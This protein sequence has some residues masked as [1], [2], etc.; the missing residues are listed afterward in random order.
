MAEENHSK[1]EIKNNED[2]VLCVDSWLNR[3]NDVVRSKSGCAIIS[4]DLPEDKTEPSV[5][6]GNGGSTDGGVDEPE[7]DESEGSGIEKTGA[8]G[9]IYASALVALSILAF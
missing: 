8:S 9:L 3:G 6:N 1:L 4:L 7:I 5:D 2:Y